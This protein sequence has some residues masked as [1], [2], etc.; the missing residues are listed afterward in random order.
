MS[1]TPA[2]PGGAAP[3]RPRV[4][5]ERLG[6][7]QAPVLVVEDLLS[8]PAPLLADAYAADYGAPAVKAYPGLRAPTPRDY[9]ATLAAALL[10]VLRDAFALDGCELAGVASDFSVVTRPPG[11]LE[12]R[13][14]IPHTD[15]T[16]PGLIALLH[17]LTP[18]GCG[19]TSFYRHR[20]TGFETVSPQRREAYERSLAAEL[21]SARLPGYI[22]GDTPLFDRIGGFDGAFNRLIAYRGSLLHSCDIADDL[23]LSDDPRS[24]RL[25]ANTF[26]TLRRPR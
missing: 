9:A 5:V 8:D 22:A 14:R 26:F 7:E 6:R 21:P 4:R 18:G 19:G 3:P 13:Q 2:A 12:V 1:G 17:Y 23:R 25:T 15:T 24:G 16:D 11:A 10:P 20:A